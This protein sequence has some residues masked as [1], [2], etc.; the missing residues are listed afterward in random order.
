MT[1]KMLKTYRNKKSTDRKFRG[2]S[3]TTVITVKTQIA[4]TYAQL[5]G[6]CSSSVD[7]NKTDAFFI[8]VSKLGKPRLN[9]P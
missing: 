1:E 8:K 7:M 2:I 5:S 9:T 6:Y 4:D 3:C